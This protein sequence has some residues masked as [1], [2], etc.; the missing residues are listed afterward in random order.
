MKQNLHCAPLSTASRRCLTGITF[1][2]SMSLAVHCA[3]L[4]ESRLWLPKSHNGLQVKLFKA[5]K[6]AESFPACIE[7]MSGTLMLDAST[8]E[9]PVFKI[10]CR[11]ED[12]RTY[13]VLMDGIDYEYLNPLPVEVEPEEAEPEVVDEEAERLAREAERVVREAEYWRLCVEGLETKTRNMAGVQWLYQEPVE[14]VFHDEEHFLATYE[15]P[16][17]AKDIQGHDLKFRGIC[18][19]ESVEDF[20][21]RLRPRR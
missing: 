18:D 20:S 19:F 11:N 12:R 13:T 2:A 21:I 5:A 9:R 10:I 4:D 6:L 1:A 8:P 7:V 14:P 3:A 17:D 16:F 15:V